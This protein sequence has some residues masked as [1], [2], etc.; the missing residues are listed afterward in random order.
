MCDIHQEALNS[1]TIRPTFIII[2]SNLFHNQET[3]NSHI[4]RYIDIS[5]L[6]FTCLLLFDGVV[7]RESAHGI[8]GWVI[9][10]WCFGRVFVV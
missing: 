9:C 1:V 7:R 2:I 6:V 10:G 5:E 4:Y 3:I 8:N